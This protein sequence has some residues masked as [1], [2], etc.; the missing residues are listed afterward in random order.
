VTHIAT[1]E[2]TPVMTGEITMSIAHQGQLKNGSEIQLVSKSVKYQ[3]WKKTRTQAD[4]A[5]VM[6]MRR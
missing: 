4:R 2:T 1:L 6:A 5:T 3:R